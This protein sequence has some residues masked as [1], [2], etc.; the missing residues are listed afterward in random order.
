ML[1]DTTSTL[2]KIRNFIFYQWTPQRAPS[3]EK[4]LMMTLGKKNKVCTDVFMSV[5]IDENVIKADGRAE[6]LYVNHTCYAT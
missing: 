3:I 5:T 6:S 2:N 4:A 1:W